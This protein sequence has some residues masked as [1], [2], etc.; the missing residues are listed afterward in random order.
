MGDRISRDH[1]YVSIAHLFAERTTC[2]RRKVGCILV[3]KRGTVLA[4]GYNGVAAGAP[5]CRGEGGKK[6]P[7]HSSSS[8]TDVDSCYAIHAEQNALLQCVDTQTIHT[9]YCTTI[10]CTSCARL[11][12]NTSCERIIYTENYESSAIRDVFTGEISQ[13]SLEEAL[14]PAL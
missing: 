10:P 7:G 5:H 6:C 11:L 1:L 9:A 2:A 4:T 12:S 13:I 8:G 3:D 14:K